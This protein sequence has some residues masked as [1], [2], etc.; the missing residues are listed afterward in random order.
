[1]A[2]GKSDC[3]PVWVFGRICGKICVKLEF[4]EKKNEKPKIF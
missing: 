2:K 3:G 4:P 1:M